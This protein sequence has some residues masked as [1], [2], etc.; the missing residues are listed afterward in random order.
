MLVS[1]VTKRPPKG[2]F[3]SQSSDNNSSSNFYK[4]TFKNVFKSVFG[5]MDLAK[6]HQADLLHR[7]RLFQEN[8]KKF[9][10]GAMQ[11]SDVGMIS[12]V[13]VVPWMENPEF[14]NELKL[15]STT[16]KIQFER[17]RNLEANSELIAEIDRIDSA[18]MNTYYKDSI[19]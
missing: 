17:K 5:V 1:I 9:Y 18:F 2:L 12:S 19:A 15:E 8:C 6:D 11:D 14:Q 16:D 13:E 10:F 7:Y 3:K 4:E